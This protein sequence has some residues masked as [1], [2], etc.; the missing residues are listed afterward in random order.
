MCSQWF[1]ERLRKHRDP[2][3]LTFPASHRD[4]LRI[5]PIVD[6]RFGAS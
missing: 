6:S 2:I 1:D 4:Q 5:S 3:S